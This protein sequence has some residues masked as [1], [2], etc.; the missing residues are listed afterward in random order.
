[1]QV[2][3]EPVV[4]RLHSVNVPVPVPFIATVPV[5]VTGIAGEISVTLTLQMI[6]PFILEQLTMVEVDRLVTITVVLP[7]L[8]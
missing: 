6:L 8:A 3:V 7:E 5:S 4:D 1:M 2:A